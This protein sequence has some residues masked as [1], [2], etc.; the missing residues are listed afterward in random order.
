V[1]DAAMV[2]SLLLPPLAADLTAEADQAWGDFSIL[3]NAR[4]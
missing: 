1:V 2:E 3:L 4:V